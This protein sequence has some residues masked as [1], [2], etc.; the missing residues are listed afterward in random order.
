M[1][2]DAVSQ[3]NRTERTPMTD[4]LWITPLEALAV[5]ISTVGMYLAML[6]LV[7]LI[8]QRMLGG[9][10]SFD[11]AAVIAFGAIIGRASLGEV[12]ELGGGL[13]ALVTL[14]V[15]QA[16]A[17]AL[18][19]FRTGARIVTSTPVLLIADGEILHR[20]LRRTHVARGELA[21]RLRLAGVHHPGEVYAAIL[22][23]TG[24]I[25]VLR[26]GEPVDPFL[27]EGVLGADQLRT[28]SG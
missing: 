5:M 23:P 6:L 3:P 16:A 19:V 4:L 12:P 9:M 13:V 28:T 10:S 11:L 21:S 17:G 8:G 20:Q 15:L 1:R 27:F 26:H 18:R 7:K 22:E 2:D 25:S 14:V 24:A